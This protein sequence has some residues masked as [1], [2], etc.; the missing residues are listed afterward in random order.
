MKYHPDRNISNKEE[1]EAK[2]KEVTKAY[3]VLSDE[4]KRAIY[5]EYGEKGLQGGGGGG[6]GGFGGG[7]PFGMFEQMSRHDNL[8]VIYQQQ[9]CLVM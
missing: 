2:F 1:A 5:D 8:T 3:E 7:D 4:K 9:H 6:G